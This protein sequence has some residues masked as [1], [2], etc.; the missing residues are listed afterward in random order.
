MASFSEQQMLVAPELAQ[1]TSVVSGGDFIYSTPSP[2]APNTLADVQA[3]ITFSKTDGLYSASF[4]LTLASNFAGEPIYYTTNDAAPGVQQA[5]SSITYSGTT[6][7]VTTAEP[8]GFATGDTVQIAGATPAVYDGA[9]AITVTGTNAFTYTLSSAPSANASGA[10]ITAT[11]GTLY[12][13]PI[14]ISTTTVVQAAMVVGGIAAPYQTETYVFPTAVAA[15]TADPTGYPTVWDGGIDDQDSPPITPC[16]RSPATPRRRSP[17]PCRR[18][19]RCR[20][21]PPTPTCSA[22][23]A[24]TR[25]LE[26]MTLEAPGSLEYFNPLSGTTAWEGLAGISMYGGVGR[27]TQY[28]KHGLQISFDQSDGP[29]YMDENIFGDGYL[30]NG[31]VLRR[32]STTAGRGAAPTRSSSST[33]GP[34]T[35]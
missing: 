25:T 26:T 1:M 2:G 3:S 8:F 21:S 17:P 16:R 24:S 27:D 4:P 34:A 29:S 13:G 5:V 31:L 33:S 28:L 23:T 11:S 22:P 32:A 6:A 10:A 20:L 15:Q 7:T 35:P 19:R 12:T 14:T 30:P 9:F 18:C